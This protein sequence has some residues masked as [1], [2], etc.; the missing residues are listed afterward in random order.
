V[1]RRDRLLAD[2]LRVTLGEDA[3]PPGHRAH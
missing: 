2:A 3:T 1:G